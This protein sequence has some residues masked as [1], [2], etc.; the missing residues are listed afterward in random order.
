MTA[1][2]LDLACGGFLLCAVLVLWRRELAVI[3]RVFAVQGALLAL[4]VALLAVQQGSAR[5]GA[6][7]VLVAVLRA[8]VLPHLLRRALAHGRRETHPSVNVTASMLTA[9]LLASLAYAVSQPLVA[10]SPSAAAVPVGL[11]VV[12]IGFFVMV[13]R[14]RALSQVVGLLLMDNGITAVGV[15]AGAAT[16][17]VAELGI[18]LDVLLAVLVLHTLTG[19]MQETWGDTDLDELRELR[20]S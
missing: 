14:R 18:S 6:V 5:L 1:R 20:D 3:V 8:A 2:L 7:A 9:A 16:G 10:L 15:L 12:L 19:R 4:I 11:T 17:L 13:T